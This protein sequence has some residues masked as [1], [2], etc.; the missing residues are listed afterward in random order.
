MGLIEKHFIFASKLVS[1]FGYT[2]EMNEILKDVRP[3]DFYNKLTWKEKSLFLCY[4]L[5]EYNMK[6]ST[7][8]RKLS[9]KPS[10]TLTKLEEMAI[11]HTIKSGLWRQ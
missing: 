6:T 11:T 7:I 4:L 9:N 10:G 2:K 3:R 8:R 1:F 5:K